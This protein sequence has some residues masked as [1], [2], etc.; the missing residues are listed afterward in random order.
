MFVGAPQVGDD[1][2][3]YEETSEEQSELFED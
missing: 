2:D 1:S 3:L